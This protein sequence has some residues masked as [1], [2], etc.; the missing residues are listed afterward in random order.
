MGLASK[1]SITG[2]AA[3]ARPGAITS[4]RTSR[5]GIL[6]NLHLKQV[7]FPLQST[8]ATSPVASSKI[9]SVT[10]LRIVVIQTIIV[11]E[12]LVPELRS[13]HPD[14]PDGN[15]LYSRVMVGID[16]MFGSRR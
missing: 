9:C 2:A 7:I 3:V 16:G 14:V 13:P 15:Q 12:V 8:A 10:N 5:W 4:E 1:L 11:S 6:P